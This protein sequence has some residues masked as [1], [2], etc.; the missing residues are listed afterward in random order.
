METVYQ[1]KP[2]ELTDEE[3]ERIGKIAKENPDLPYASL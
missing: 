1:L 2:D 3:V